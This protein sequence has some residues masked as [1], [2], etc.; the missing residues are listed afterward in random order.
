MVQTAY[1][2]LAKLRLFTLMGKDFYLL[3]EG[4]GLLWLASDEA[5]AKLPF[6]EESILRDYELK[7]KQI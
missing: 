7:L 1:R 3:T 6:E 5:I 4:N 2:L